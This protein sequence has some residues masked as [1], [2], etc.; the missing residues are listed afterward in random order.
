MGKGKDKNA[1]KMEILNLA[2]VHRD[3]WESFLV[4]EQTST[5]K[6]ESVIDD[7][8]WYYR[9]ELVKILG[10]AQTARFLEKQKFE[11]GEDSDGDSIYK[12]RQR[13]SKTEA[14]KSRK[15]TLT[16]EASMGKEADLDSLADAM[17]QWF[18]A[19]ANPCLL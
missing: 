7:S 15:A 6:I 17:D 5:E 10:A 2:L 11:A 1:Q 16:K 19:I 14:K 8:T 18:E 3:R 12:K 4:T 9:G 13:S